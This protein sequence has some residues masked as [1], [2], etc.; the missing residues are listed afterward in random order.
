MAVRNHCKEH[1][2]SEQLGLCQDFKA[3]WGYGLQANVSEIE[4][5]VPSTTKTKKS[6]KYWVLIGNREWMK[7]NHLKVDNGIDK[8]MS[9]HEHDGHTAVLIAIDGNSTITS[10]T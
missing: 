10:F 3:I 4:N 1:F 6:T 5:L 7:R 9:L 2:A 8:T